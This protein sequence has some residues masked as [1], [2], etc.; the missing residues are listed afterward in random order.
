MITIVRG[1]AGIR[2]MVCNQMLLPTFITP[3]MR[4]AVRLFRAFASICAKR[5]CGC[6]FLSFLGRIRAHASVISNLRKCEI[7]SADFVR[8]TEQTGEA[9]CQ[10]KQP[11]TRRIND[12]MIGN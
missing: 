11:L 7:N 6:P 12:R 10:R 9:N 1:T 8:F 4:L 2:I 3:L 5:K